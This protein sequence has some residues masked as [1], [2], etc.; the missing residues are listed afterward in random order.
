MTAEALPE[1]MRALCLTDYG[2]GPH[3]LRLVRRPVPKPAP[4]Q[5]LVR[6]KAAPIHPAD[7]MFMRG[8]YGVKKP[9]PV[10]PGFEGSGTVVAA[11][12]LAGRLLVGRRVG[13]S[14]AQSQDGTWAEYVV[15]PM[16]QCLPLLPGIDDE[17]GASLFVNPFSAWAMME[18]ARQGKHRALV[19]SAAASTLGRMLLR[20]SLQ[21]GIPLVN[22]VRRAE[23]EELLRGLGAEHVV[24]SSEPEFEE[25]LRLR[26]HELGVTLGFDAVA[27][28]MTGQLLQALPE[29]GTVV[30]YGA[31][32][33]EES[34][35][36]VGELIFRRQKVEGFWLGTWLSQGFGK[37]Q[38]RALVEVPLRMGKAFETPVRA[39][40]PLEAAEEAL[41][42]AGTDMTSGKVFFTPNA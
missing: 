33:G 32:S 5:L 11:G 25:R 31:L 27:G 17:Q 2:G 18:L 30:V 28:A 21:A 19:Q 42:L 37:S 29:G 23:Q 24:N 40:F 8:Q 20:L 12:S 16:S 9:L 15:V 3:A 26:C 22:I 1:T 36:P 34:R 7:Q 41:R 38:L 4:G 6:V 13:V 39:C 10:V 35:V 14:S